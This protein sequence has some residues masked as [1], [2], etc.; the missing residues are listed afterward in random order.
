MEFISENK[1]SEELI[2]SFDA[3]MT[4]E[5]AK[6]LDKYIYTTSFD[7]LQRLALTT[8]GPSNKQT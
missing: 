7:C 6:R 8:E 4:L 2:N 3:E 1:M 5:L